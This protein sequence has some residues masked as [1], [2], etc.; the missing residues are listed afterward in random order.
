MSAAA[1]VR[2][3]EE[4]PPVTLTPGIEDAIRYCA[5]GWVFP[6]FFFDAD[7]ARQRGMPGLLVP[8]PLKLGFIYRA[9]EAWLDGRG[10]VRSVRAAH[11]RPDLQGRAI[12]VSG[13]VVRVYDEGGARRADIELVI[14]NEDGAP[15]VRGFAS[16]Q[17]S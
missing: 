14:T 3:G 15:S 8:G 10:F 2:E 1:D 17:F 12:T 16:V 4:I 13:T 5:L 6:P 9:V 7:Q 11:R